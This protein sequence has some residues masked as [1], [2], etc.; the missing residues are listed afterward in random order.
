MQSKTG[1]TVIREKREI[2]EAFNDFFST[3]GSEL[4]ARSLN[5]QSNCVNPRPLIVNSVASSM[6]LF[7]VTVEEVY[8][9][10]R[11]LKVDK[12]IGVDRISNR[13][14]KLCATPISCILCRCI[15]ASFQ[16]GIYPVVFKVAKVIP[17]HKGGGKELM[18]NYRPISVLTRVNKVFETLINKRLMSFFTKFKVLADSQHGFRR[19]SSTETAATEVLNYIY[20][21]L[22]RRC[23]VHTQIVSG[24]EIRIGLT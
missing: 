3:I 7:E 17:L 18:S 10:L 2:A 15:N 5:F 1:T 20:K 9:V 4:S 14:L 16:S 23:Q 12:A 19:G 21:K 8:E 11:K 22:N 13:V 24:Q 6:R